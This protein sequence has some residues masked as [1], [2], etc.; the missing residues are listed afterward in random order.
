MNVN[1]TAEQEKFIAEKV[2]SS[3]YSS[4]EG[5]VS[6][7]LRLVQA[8]EEYERHLAELRREIDIGLEQIRRGEV[9]DGREAIA[10]LLEKNRMRPRSE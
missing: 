7:G 10:R 1:L 5:V 9:V 4:P 3:H 6:E 8:K 2:R